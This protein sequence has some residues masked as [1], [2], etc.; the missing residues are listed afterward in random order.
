M[1]EGSAR[2]ETHAM[3]GR[4][5]ERAIQ[6]GWRQSLELRDG[7]VMEGAQTLEQQWRRIAQFPIPDNLTG[8]RVLEIGAAD[9]WFSFEMER[10]GAHAVALE[11]GD[12]KI[13]EAKKLLRSHAD[14]RIGDIAALTWRELG[15]FDIILCCGVLDELADP[16][17]VLENICG[18]ARNMV[19]VETAADT[20]LPFEAAG[21]ARVRIESTLAGRRHLTC[22]RAWDPASMPAAPAAPPALVCFEN[23]RTR[24]HLFSPAA[25]DTVNF[26]FKWDGEELSVANVFPEVSGFG[27]QPMRI[28]PSDGGW[29]G[30]FGLPP[31]LRPG[32]HDFT[33]R[34]AGSGPSRPVRIAVDVPDEACRYWP[35][36]ASN[37]LRIQSITDGKTFERWR[38]R[39]G[40][41]SAISVWVQGLPGSVD[42]GEIRLRLNGTDLPAIW[43]EPAGG[44]ARQ[45]NAV[46]PP[47]V[48]PGEA[49]VSVVLGSR[50]SAARGIEL[51]T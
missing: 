22:W 37:N 51:H 16:L 12:T 35:A 26:Y 34:V 11:S 1:S 46:V 36:E 18:M 29:Q 27:V 38:V 17:P 19:C 43:L 31:G 23:S 3:P 44:G 33:L 6:P 7:T 42:A 24:D 10:R 4:P 47:G 13:G 45:V 32:W 50:E 28:G 5:L 30:T 49:R 14:I 39:V 2:G 20:T 40:E 15:T 21:F 41:D 25:Q 9:G 48:A 8:K